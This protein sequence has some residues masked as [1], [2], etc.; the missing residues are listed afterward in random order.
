MILH[1][2]KNA[3][4]VKSDFQAEIGTILI[5]GDLDELEQK[6]ISEY[7]KYNKSKTE[8]IEELKNL[9]DKDSEIIST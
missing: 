6:E 2:K 8:I 3:P 9:S 5:E 7:F 1:E 4:I